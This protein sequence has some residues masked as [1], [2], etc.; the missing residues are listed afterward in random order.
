MQKL[1]SNSFTIVLLVVVG[2]LVTKMVIG[3]SVAET[4]AALA[5]V[6][7]LDS[8]IAQANEQGKVVFAVATAPWC[9]PCQAYKR[10]ALADERVQT[11]IDTNAVGIHINTDE[12][13]EDANRLGVRSIPATYII[14]DGTVVQSF[15]GLARTDELLSTLEP[16]AVAR[17]E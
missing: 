14:K 16:F 10:G 11:W 17:A 1:L 13:P 5:N 4:P 15:A 8:A 12:N 3:P 6:S 9:G 7:T 2:L